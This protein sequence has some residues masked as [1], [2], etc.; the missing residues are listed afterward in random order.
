LAN[1]LSTRV[2]WFLYSLKLLR[3]F[4]GY[5]MLDYKEVTRFMRVVQFKKLAEI[6][7]KSLEQVD[8]MEDS[9]PHL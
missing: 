6:E 4:R 1:I 5:K 8:E 9:E 7:L 2:Y 3:L